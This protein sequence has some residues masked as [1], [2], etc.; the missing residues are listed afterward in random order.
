MSDTA[1]IEG[2]VTE[3]RAGGSRVVHIGGPQ[4]NPATPAVAGLVAASVESGFQAVRAAGSPAE[5]GLRFGVAS[6]IVLALGAT[7]VKD[8]R[9]AV[10]AVHAHVLPAVRKGPLV[11]AVDDA[12]WLDPESGWWLRAL[13]R[14]ARTQPLLIVLGSTGARVSV[15]DDDPAARSV[16]LG[17]GAGAVEPVLDGIPGDVLRLLQAIAV[18][19]GRL[20]LDLVRELAGSG[21]MPR[22]AQLDAAL[23]T[24]Y[25]TDGRRGPTAANPAVAEALLESMTGADRADLCTR[26][27]ELSYRAGL[28][29]ADTAAFVINVPPMRAPWVVRALRQAAADAR[30][31]GEHEFAAR[32]LERALA[33]PVDETTEVRLLAE[34]GEV[35]LHTA[36][37]LGERR[38][39]RALLGAG[40]DRLARTMLRA[41]DVL[42]LHHCADA[43]RDAIAKACGRDDLSRAER[44]GLVALHWL[45]ESGMPSPPRPGTNP[46]PELPDLPSDPAQAGVAAW[47]RA[48]NG[49]NLRAVRT[50]AGAALDGQ[51][52]TEALL[53]PRICAANALVLTDDAD[54]AGRA[55]S[56]VLRE[57]RRRAIPVAAASALLSRSR[58]QLATGRFSAALRDL[59][60]AK[61]EV[62]DDRWPPML[63]PSVVATEMIIYTVLGRHEEAERAEATP[64]APAAERGY[65]WTLLL[66]AMGLRRISAGVDVAKGR[67]Y[68]LEVGRRLMSRQ[69][70]NPALLPWRST[71]ALVSQHSDSIEGLIEGELAA[72]HAWGTNSCLGQAHMNAGVARRDAASQGHLRAAAAL[73]R[74]SPADTH[75]VRA[76]LELATLHADE[77]DWAEVGH[78]LEEAGDLAADLGWDTV[79]LR[80]AELSSRRAAALLGA[81]HSL[82]EVEAKVAGMAADRLPNAVIARRLSMSTRAVEAHLTGVYH[83]LDIQGRGQLGSVLRKAE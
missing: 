62:R 83:K 81:R 15:F 73:L 58:L 56:E 60:A 4:G 18:A 65:G 45:G 71:A 37:E 79:D 50:L 22:A 24:G 80:I 12:Q 7:P 52:V 33:E 25:V 38:I 34:L 13:A 55:L 82:S 53:A 44:D 36:Y 26:A 68:L 27:A 47:R 54:L 35:Q 49:R 6:Q 77:G 39:A 43:G 9:A 42:S 21:S 30:S 17:P 8:D 1:T 46:V 51:A 67:D 2:I 64:P 19:H 61:R 76:L 23:R 57:A 40:G 75:Y 78:L 10:R 32:L 63:L 59:A 14:R 16:W 11:I 72:A 20:E 41:A 3:V 69:W 70:D 74:D 28:S 5:T 29:E 66:F 48:A 31:R